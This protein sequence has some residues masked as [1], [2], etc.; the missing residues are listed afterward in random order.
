MPGFKC[1]DCNFETKRKSNWE[2]HLQ[3]PKHI[4]RHN[5]GRTSYS[6]EKCNYHTANK[7]DF[8]RHLLRAKHIK[9]TSVD[10]SVSNT[11]NLLVKQ[12][13]YLEGLDERVKKIELIVEELDERTKKIEL[14][15]E[16]LQNPDT[17]T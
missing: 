8:T 16:S 11:D 3:T 1:I 17:V 13:A 7:S 15:V 12:I 6:C 14:T 5:T 10:T 4:S 2:R 9:N